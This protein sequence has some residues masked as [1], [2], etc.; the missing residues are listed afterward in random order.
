LIAICKVECFS[1]G[2]KLLLYKILNLLFFPLLRILCA[3]WL[4][5]R[6]KLS[7][8]SWCGHLKFH[9]LRPR[10]CLNNLFRTLS[11]CFGVI[12]KTPVLI[13]RYNFVKKFL[14]ATAIAIR[15]WQYMTWSSFCSGV[16]ECGTKLVHHILVP[17]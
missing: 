17:K 14:S 12:S 16:K 4:E 6:K 10:G 2:D 5:I 3:L 7:T 11:L 1:G 13:S 9:F 8:W 15:S